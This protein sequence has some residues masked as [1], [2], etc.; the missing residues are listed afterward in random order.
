M[1]GSKK[2]KIDDKEYEFTML[3]PE[4]AL[5]VTLR[6]AKLSG[7]PIGGAI[8]SI[9]LVPGAQLEDMKLNPKLLGD[10]ISK[11]FEKIDETETIDTFKIILSS[12][13]FG[14]KPLDLQHH[15]FHGKTFHLVKV[16]KAGMEENFTDFFG[17]NSG[18]AKVLKG[19]LDSIQAL[20]T[21]TGQ[22]GE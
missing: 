16:F 19:F 20:R 4:S 3:D 13:Y 1:E 18:V 22:S 2:Q 5:K 12:I 10:A 17:G 8:G 11:M 7:Q 15:N 21:V 6:I 14:G 9:E